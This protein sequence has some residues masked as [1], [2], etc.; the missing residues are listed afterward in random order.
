MKQR[1]ITAVVALSMLAVIVLLGEWAVFVLC[2]IFNAMALYEY[3]KTVK[4]NAKTADYILMIAAGSALL[5]VGAFFEKYLLYAL[6]AALIL[7]FIRNLFGVPDEAHA[8]NSVW[9]IVY[10]SL[11]LSFAA[12]MIFNDIGM[13][14]CLVVIIDT[15]ICDTMAYFGGYLFGKHKLC[16]AVSPKKTIEGS[17]CGFIFAVLGFFAAYYLPDYLSLP[18]F[19]LWVYIVCGI[20]I[21]A[22]S[23]F[24]DLSASLIKRKYQAKDY[25]NL[26]P[27]H[28]GALDRIDGMLFSLASVYIFLNVFVQL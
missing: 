20:L 15:V 7:V 9:G 19:D 1:V 5:F 26:L 4:R 23:Q 27:G 10:I 17:V 28:G 21:G 14:F 12:A 6:A 11:F 3:V 22:F 24:G 16:K 2:L 8:V 13:Y 18:E 25:G